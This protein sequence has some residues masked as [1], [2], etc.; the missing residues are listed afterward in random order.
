MRR[1]IKEQYRDQLFDFC[2]QMLQT[3][4]YDPNYFAVKGFC[5]ES[6]MTEDEKFEFCFVFNGF[7]HFGSAE[8]FYF[9]RGLDVSKMKYGKSRRGFMG[10]NK[11]RDF[12]ASGRSLKPFIFQ[13]MTGG[14]SAWKRT[15]DRLLSVP[16][17]GHW[18]AYYLCDMFKVILGFDITA[19]DL[20]FLSSN[21]ENRGPIS[22]LRFLTGIP[23][24]VLRED[25]SLHVAIYEETLDGVPFEGMEQFE[26]I[27]CNFLSLHK[28]MY[29]VGRDI[30]R[31]IQMMSGLGP[32]W[33]NAR[34]RY[35]PQELLGE[36]NGWDGIRKDRMGKFEPG[37]LYQ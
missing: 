28:N 35:F 36:T 2:R 13:N 30:D 14:K 7:Y 24:D 17:C 3:R 12:I 6:G 11:V 18:S 5:E 15:Y 19:P 26:S 1:L 27:L 10:N 16:G 20:G 9:N 33:W 25:V 31:Q 34:R 29:Y 8:A 32:K 21:T 23:E 37:R 4:D 22:G